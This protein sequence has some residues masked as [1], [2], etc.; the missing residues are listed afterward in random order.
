M[1]GHS[2]TPDHPRSWRARLSLRDGLFVSAG[3]SG[4][5]SLIF[6]IESMAQDRSAMLSSVVSIGQA[7]PLFLACLCAWVLQQYCQQ[8]RPFVVKPVL[9]IASAIFSGAVWGW[10]VG[11][12]IWIFEPVQLHTP[13][14]EIIIGTAMSGLFVYAL[15]AGLGVVTGGVASEDNTLFGVAQEDGVAGETIN[16]RAI[17]AC[18]VS[19]VMVGAAVTLG[20]RVFTAASGKGSP[21][22]TSLTSVGIALLA[23]TADLDVIPVAHVPGSNDDIS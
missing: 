5:A 18:A 1:S 15:I 23:A 16:V 17:N 13:L 20:A 3:L 12:F 6:F 22:A 9:H 7:V 14:I 10:G 2:I 19:D 8:V 21:T 4:F 11:A